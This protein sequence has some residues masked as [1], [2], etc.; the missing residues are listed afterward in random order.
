[1]QVLILKKTRHHNLALFMG[2]SFTLPNLAIITSFCHGNTL[3]KHLHVWSETFS[4]EKCYNIAKQVATGMGYLHARGIV[5]KGLHTRNI[6]LDKD[7]VV[8][9]DTGLSS[10]SDGLCFPNRR[11]KYAVIVP[12]TKLYY[13]APELMREISCAPNVLETGDV[14]H[15][16]EKTDIYAFGTVFY[17]LLTR[18]YPFAS[19]DATG[20]PLDVTMVIYQVGRGSRQDIPSR[21]APKKIKDLIWECWQ[22]DPKKRIPF[23]TIWDIITKVSRKKTP[24]SRSPS[25]PTALSR[26]SE[27]LLRLTLNY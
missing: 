24:I 15:Y 26:S 11:S 3:H 7:K 13:L 18:R 6:F 19:L 12:R 20:F 2:A 14:Y 4:T 1:M 16:T 17:E 21:D 25:V 27:D 23:S 5:H 22:L 8:I 9:T 10:V